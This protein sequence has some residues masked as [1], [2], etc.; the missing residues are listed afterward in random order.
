MG[1]FFATVVRLRGKPDGGPDVDSQHRAAIL[2]VDGRIARRIRLLR[3]PGKRSHRSVGLNPPR[4]VLPTPGVTSWEDIC[5][6][7]KPSTRKPEA[8]P[9]VPSR[10]PRARETT[11]RK[12]GPSANDPQRGEEFR[13]AS[14]MIR[15]TKKG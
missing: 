9:D 7:R 11:R 15:A 14:E 12:R 3:N 4:N 10:P 2:P 5:M 13:K 8:V 1:S 6:A